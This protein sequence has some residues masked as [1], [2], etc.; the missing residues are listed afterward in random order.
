M[1]VKLPLSLPSKGSRTEPRSRQ[2]ASAAWTSSKPG[3]TSGR[4]A[5]KGPSAIPLS[6]TSCSMSPGARSSDA[7]SVADSG[8]G[9]GGGNGVATASDTPSATAATSLPG[10]DAKR[11]EEH[12]SELQSLM[13]NSDAVLWL[14]QNIE[15]TSAAHY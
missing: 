12:T 4:G 1:A 11:S 5:S 3:S 6:A 8:D 14:K 15:K 2:A 10:D 9:T 7:S 13:R